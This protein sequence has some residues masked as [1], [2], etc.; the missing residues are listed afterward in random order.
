[1]DLTWLGHSCFRIRSDETSIIT[2]PYPPSIGLELREPAPTLATVSHRHPNHSC[3]EALAG[4]PRVLDGPGEYELSGIYVT[5]VMTPKGAGDPPSKRNTAYLFEIE[6]LR[7]CHLGDVSARL[8]P[9]QVQE[10]SPLDI[11]LIPV[12][13]GCTID[14][15]GAAEMVRA[16]GPRVVVPMHYRLPGLRFASAAPA[17]TEAAAPVVQEEPSTDLAQEPEPAS[18]DTVGIRQLGLEGLMGSSQ[19]APAAPSPAEPT[20]QPAQVEE[21][22]RQDAP[23]A[24]SADLGAVDDFLREMGLRDVA[25][26]PRLTISA[27]SLPAELR[28][29]LLEPRGLPRSG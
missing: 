28:I 9:R 24:R 13:G 21:P 5:G 25:P 23:P 4:E 2:D 16:L 7:V 22:A 1:M 26:Q 8:T 12:G 20:P 27:T 18:G 15:P 6:R 10:L 14:A 3:R 11:L 19:P 29:V 17:P